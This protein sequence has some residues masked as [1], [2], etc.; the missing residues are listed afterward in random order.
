MALGNAPNPIIKDSEPEPE[1]HEVGQHQRR[2]A[3]RKRTSVEGVFSGG[4]A[5]R[6]GSTAIMAAGDGQA[7]AREIVG[8]IDLSRDRDQGPGEPR[9]A[10]YGDSAPR[11]RPSS[12]STT[13]PKASSSSTVHSPLVAKAAQAG[14][15]VRVLPWGKGELIPLTLADWDAEAGTIDLVIQARG[16]Q[17]HGDQ[18]DEGR[19]GVHRHRRAARPAQQAAPLRGRPD[20]GVRAP[21]GSACRRSIRSCAS[22]CGSATTSR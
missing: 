14:Q 5:A 12:R 17:Q 13:S 9:R 18:P 10:V 1:D 7:A 11:R 21:A 4:D 20:R 3:A 22:T 19:R 16:H 15:F 6:G 8:D 2:R